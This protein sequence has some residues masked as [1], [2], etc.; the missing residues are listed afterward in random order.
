MTEFLFGL[1]IYGSFAI[2]FLCA[3][4]MGRENAEPIP[5][6][7]EGGDMDLEDGFEDQCV[8]VGN[9]GDLPDR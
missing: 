9:K 2:L 7:A 4:M 5:E 8:L 3:I 6:L 1:I